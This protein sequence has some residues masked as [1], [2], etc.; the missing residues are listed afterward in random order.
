MSQAA[1]GE[2]AAAHEREEEWRALRAEHG[3]LVGWLHGIALEPGRKAQARGQR[4]PQP[5]PR[6][7]VSEAGLP[8]PV[9]RAR[10]EGASGDARSVDAAAWACRWTTCAR[11]RAACRSGRWDPP[12]GADFLA[13][14][15]LCGDGMGVQGSR[16]WQSPLS[17]H[18]VGLELVHT[19]G[20]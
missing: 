16:R 1:G 7:R 4:P 10:W 13:P 11:W 14:L 5:A 19:T 8:H 2:A 17:P 12:P 15:L 20:Y 6:A 18:R 9:T 3:S